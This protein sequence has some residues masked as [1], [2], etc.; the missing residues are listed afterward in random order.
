LFDDIYNI[1]SAGNTRQVANDITFPG[2]LEADFRHAQPVC[3]GF[4]N[5]FGNINV[6]SGEFARIIGVHLQ[7]N[8]HPTAQVQSQDGFGFHPQELVCAGQVNKN[9]SRQQH[10]DDN[11]I[12]G[13]TTHAFKASDSYNCQL[14]AGDRL[15]YTLIVAR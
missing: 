3:S 5:T 6:F 14:G 15:D 12:D 9:G 8:L 7:D 2:R 4:Q 1:F 11:Q 13:T 10:N